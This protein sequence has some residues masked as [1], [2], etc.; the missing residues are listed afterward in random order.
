MGEGRRQSSGAHGAT[1]SSAG[2]YLV[3]TVCAQ[4]L[5]TVH[6]EVL[7]TVYRTREHGVQRSTEQSAHGGQVVLL[8]ERP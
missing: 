4:V 2:Q 7:N 5:N 8:R 6:T 1:R 3:N